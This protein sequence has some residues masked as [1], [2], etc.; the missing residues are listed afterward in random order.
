MRVAVIGASGN[1]GTSVLRALMG[2]S[3]VSSIVAVARRS[4]AGPG[5]LEWRERDVTRDALRPDLES[6]DA[7]ICLSWLIQPSRDEATL[8]AT[9][10]EGSRR[11]FEASAQAGVPALLYSS[12][13]GA[14]SPGS[15]K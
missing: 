8:S 9:N 14:Y 5:K 15:K 4:A 1:I 2:D 12:S 7:V 10:V 3:E 6:V 13:V 11:V